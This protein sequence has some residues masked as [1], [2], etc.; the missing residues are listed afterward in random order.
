MDKKIEEK[1]VMTEAVDVKAAKKN[2]EDVAGDG[3]KH[4][5][6]VHT[7]TGHENK[8]KVNLEKRIENMNM[9]EKIFRVEV[10]QQTVTQVKNGKKHERE[11]KLYPGYVFVE[12]IMDNDSWY[13]VRNT[14]GVT[15]FVGS[16]KKPIP[17]AESDIK[18]ILHRTQNQVQKIQLDVKVGDKV[19]I[20]SGPF[21][22]FVG[23]ITE[24]HPDKA[25]L[26]ANVSIFGRETP[27]EL[28][29]KQI[30]KL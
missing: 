22:E 4:W 21:A 9:T 23:D 30:Q 6:I 29:Y 3:K 16:A 11:E 24:V 2:D 19:R 20:I 10:P 25:K 8:V 7:Q 1:E 18:K 5:Y 13:V 26:R 27:V 15:K 12:M 28:E 14:A 17:A